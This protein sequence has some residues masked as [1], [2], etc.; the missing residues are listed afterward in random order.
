MA[1]TVVIDGVEYS[2]RYELTDLGKRLI[3]ENDQQLYVLLDQL[4]TDIG[5]LRDKLKIQN[6]VDEMDRLR[7]MADRAIEILIGKFAAK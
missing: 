6:N 7:M 4:R 5:L 1:K 2:P 3:D